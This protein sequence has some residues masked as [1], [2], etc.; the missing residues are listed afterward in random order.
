MRSL[1][2]SVPILPSAAYV[3]NRPRRVDRFGGST[4]SDGSQRQR[5]CA[6]CVPPSRF[7]R[8]L[9]AFLRPDSPVS[10]LLAG[11]VGIEGLR[12][13]LHDVEALAL[14]LV[15]KVLRDG[16]VVAD[17]RP[18]ERRLWEGEQTLR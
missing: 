16:R 15:A 14:P 13:D 17:R 7:S 6:R 1:R 4:T 18:P 3:L 9:A 8:P 12:I 11:K 10:V 2:S 5:P